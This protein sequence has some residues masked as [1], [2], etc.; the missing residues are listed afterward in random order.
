MAP[1]FLATE[2]LPAFGTLLAWALALSSVP[3]LLRDK[4]QGKLSCD[5]TPYPVAFTSCFIMVVYGSI[6]GDKWPFF[7][8]FPSVLCFGFCT[9]T[10]LRLCRDDSIAKRMEM[11][12]LAGLALLGVSVVLA[13]GPI[14]IEDVELRVRI[15]GAIYTPVGIMQWLSPC[16]ETVSAIRRCD[17]SFLSAPL[18]VASWLCTAFWT[19]YGLL[20]GQPAMWMPNGVGNALSL[21]TLLV[22]LWVP[23]K[24]ATVH[25]RPHEELLKALSACDRISL[26]CMSFDKKFYLQ[27]PGNLTSASPVT[28]GSSTTSWAVECA[29]DGHVGFRAED[30]RCLQLVQSSEAH[31]SSWCPA[32]FQLHAVPSGDFG[33]AGTFLPVEGFEK[34][35]HGSRRVPGTNRDMQVTHAQASVAFWNPLHSVFLRLNEIGEFDSSPVCRPVDGKVVIP[36]GWNWE[37]FIVEREGECD[38]D[39]GEGVRSAVRRRGLRVLRRS[40]SAE[41]ATPSVL[42]LPAESAGTFQSV[43]S[44]AV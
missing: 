35:S 30:G 28:A 6:V 16:V 9:L 12:M 42:G 25:T 7:A 10:S 44:G 11:L 17:S 23:S 8:C 22:K 40:S 4:R 37:R 38:A 33:E 29:G 43:V 31:S 39:A 3:A 34:E 18:A 14:F 32:A 27:A 5:P 2:V 24:G 26:R 19:T 13:A 36:P 15:I 21:F 41:G 1:S 20:T